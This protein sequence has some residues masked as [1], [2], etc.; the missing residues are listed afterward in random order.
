MGQDTAIWEWDG[1]GLTGLIDLLAADERVRRVRVM[2]L[3]PEHV[4]DAFLRYMAGQ[5]KLCRYLDV[6]FQHS[7]PESPAAHGPP[8]GRERVSR[9]A[10]DGR[11]G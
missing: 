2:Y 7:H 5:P 11:A 9:P 1:L 6:P 4:T 3:Q 8:G 10:G